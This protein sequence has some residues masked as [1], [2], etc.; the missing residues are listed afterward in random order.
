MGWFVVSEGGMG[1]PVH[2]VVLW[3]LLL[4]KAISKEQRYGVVVMDKREDICC[5]SVEIVALAFGEEREF[6]V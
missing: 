3:V 1:F 6:V 4:R 2:V 5:S